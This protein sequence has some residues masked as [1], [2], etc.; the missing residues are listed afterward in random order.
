MWT[1]ILSPLLALTSGRRRA[2]RPG[3]SR[4]VH[5]GGWELQPASTPAITQP[6]RVRSCG[7][8]APP[9]DWSR[10]CNLKVCCLCP[11]P[12]PAAA[13]S[14]LM[15][16]SRCGAVSIRHVVLPLL[17]VGHAAA[18]ALYL[19]LTPSISS[20]SCHCVPYGRNSSACF[21]ASVCVCSAVIWNSSSSA[22]ASLRTKE[23]GEPP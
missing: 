3:A 18:R 23:A 9:P 11:A 10:G 7:A 22:F 13:A 20:L 15:L 5:G 17:L 14:R 16:P 2:S 8:R 12:P 19:A 1:L 6:P 21:A 4:A